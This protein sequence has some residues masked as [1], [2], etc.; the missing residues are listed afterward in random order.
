MKYILAILSQTSSLFHY[1]G[2][3]ASI[4]SIISAV[5]SIVSYMKLKRIKKKFI[6]NIHIY[7]YIEIR[8]HLKT[9]RTE[10]RRL[11]DNGINPIRGF[12]SDS[13]F[14]SIIAT[15]DKCTNILGFDGEDNRI[16]L[17][18]E[19]ICKYRNKDKDYLE[20]NLIVI[21]QTISLINTIII[22]HSGE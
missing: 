9:I 21:N 8:E 11:I 7:N 12:N 1:I 4:L 22:D 17:S 10:I 16:R 2:I 18:I 20:D 6:M 15:K 14:D 19:S 5:I 3:I 13:V